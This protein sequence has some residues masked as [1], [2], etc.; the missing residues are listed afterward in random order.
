MIPLGISN[1]ISDILLIISFIIF[2]GSKGA[3]PKWPYILPIVVLELHV[4][5]MFYV[6]V[7]NN[8]V[9][10]KLTFYSSV[11]LSFSVLFTSSICFLLY[12][13]NIYIAIIACINFIAG[14]I[15]GIG[16]KVRKL[17]IRKE[18]YK[19]VVICMNKGYEDIYLWKRS[20]LS[21]LNGSLDKMYKTFLTEKEKHKIGSSLFELAYYDICK[22]NKKDGFKVILDTY[23]T[24]TIYPSLRDRYY[25]GR[26]H[27]YFDNFDFKTDP[28]YLFFATYLSDVHLAEHY[29]PVSLPT[30]YSS[31]DVPI[32]GAKF[33]IKD[34]LY[35]Y[36]MRWYANIKGNIKSSFGENYDENQIKNKFS[37]YDKLSDT[38]INCCGYSAIYNDK[39]FS[40]YMNG[41][42]SFSDNDYQYIINEA[43]SIMPADRNGVI[44]FVDNDE[45]HEIYNNHYKPLRD[46][47][48]QSGY[49]ISI[50][51]N[52]EDSN[53]KEQRYPIIVIDIVSSTENAKQIY[54]TIMS[55]VHDNYPYMV[56]ISFL[57]EKK[58]Q[59]D[60]EKTFIKDMKEIVLSNEYGARKYYE[61]IEDI[62][63]LDVALEIFNNKAQIIDTQKRYEK[64]IRIATDYPLGYKQLY[65]DIE[66]D[67]DEIVDDIIANEDEIMKQHRIHSHLQLAEIQNI[68]AAKALASDFPLAFKH[69]YK[70]LSVNDINADNAQEIIMKRAKFYGYELK[71]R[72][73]LLGELTGL[74]LA[75]SENKLMKKLNGLVSANKAAFDYYYPLIDI[76]SIDWQT[77]TSIINDESILYGYTIEQKTEWK[78]WEESTF[79][80]PYKFIFP[81]YPKD[82]IPENDLNNN[83]DISLYYAEH[84]NQ[85]LVWNFKDGKEGARRFLE[86]EISRM[87]TSKF[88]KQD[89]KWLTFVCLPA[90]TRMTNALRYQAFSESICKRLGM[91]NGFDHIKITKEKTPSHLGGEDK[92]EFSFDK[93]FFNNAN[94]ILFDDIVTKGD[95]MKNFISIMKKHNARV[96]CC[97]SI[98][99]TV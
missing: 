13:S 70:S 89:F 96:M 15:F 14:I 20:Y 39:M 78:G 92:A 19:Y 18:K 24:I 81:Y 6:L 73:K 93:D 43:S 28:Y 56:Y 50:V 47:F 4:I 49:R 60:A 7:D 87:L 75:H 76:R 45:K 57:S 8:D 79:K 38:I 44:V 9:S 80:V 95:T 91:R 83:D 62:D 25:K 21:K 32:V 5:W 33:P 99:K 34:K 58:E 55:Q 82:R 53:C 31:I 1:I 16:S 17:E 51:E 74:L 11:I 10:K 68:N 37:N 26:G 54:K 29:A 27:Y 64:A 12:G 35:N 86:E 46:Y 41:S 90:S 52:F 72:D 85:R 94:V 36:N 67:D 88:E 2:I 59:S 84:G 61:H 77:A 63:Y 66:I 40:N 42:Q 22:Q 48:N 65:D 23:K 98:G 69:Y 3:I 71:T 97:M 30:K